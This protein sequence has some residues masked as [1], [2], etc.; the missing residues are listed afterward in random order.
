VDINSN[1]EYK[2]TYT[3]MQREVTLSSISAKEER[4]MIELFHINIWLKKTK[5]NC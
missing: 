1:I 5:V 2:V 3:S 4:E